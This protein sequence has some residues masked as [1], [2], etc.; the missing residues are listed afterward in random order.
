MDRTGTDAHYRR[1]ARHLDT[2]PGGFPATD[3]GVHLRILRRLFTPE[4]ASLAV[5]SPLCRNRRASSPAGRGL[6][7]TRRSRS[8]R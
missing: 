2:L 3:T 1:L 7:S 4:E 5:T 6:T 8:S